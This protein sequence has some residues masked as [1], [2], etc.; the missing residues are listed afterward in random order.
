LQPKK[1]MAIRNAV[2][3]AAT[4]KPAPKP[5]QHAGTGVLNETSPPNE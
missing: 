1:R 4:N 2:T 3:I 5:N